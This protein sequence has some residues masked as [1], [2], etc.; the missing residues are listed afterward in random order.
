MMTE[1]L[2]LG[3][4]NLVTSLNGLSSSQTIKRAKRRVM[5]Q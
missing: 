3:T 5:D 4:F 1:S 2:Q